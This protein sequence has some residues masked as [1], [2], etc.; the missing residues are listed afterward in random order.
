M[1]SFRLTAGTRD[2]HHGYNFTGSVGGTGLQSLRHSCRSELTR[3][4]TS[5][6]V[7]TAEIAEERGGTANL[8]FLG[9]WSFLPTSACR[10]AARTIS[11]LTA[12]ERLAYS[13]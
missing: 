3:Q 13:L 4:G 6:S 2:L 9:G 5:L 8:R 10:H 1:G 11:S 12:N 7:V